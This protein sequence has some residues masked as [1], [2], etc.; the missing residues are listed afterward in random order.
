[1]LGNFDQIRKVYIFKRFQTASVISFTIFCTALVRKGYTE[2]RNSPS[3][4][5]PEAKSIKGAHELISKWHI[6]APIEG[7]SEPA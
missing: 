3:K 5:C 2:V 4:A 6:S 1:M 7:Q